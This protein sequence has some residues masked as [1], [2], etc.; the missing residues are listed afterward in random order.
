MESN[1][2]ALSYL[3]EV[4]DWMVG[5]PTEIVTMWI[6]KHGSE[7]F[8]GQYDDVEVEHKWRHAQQHR[9]LFGITHFL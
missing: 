8:D 3:Q 2:P 4:R 1:Q 5:H 7:C 9:L 6:S